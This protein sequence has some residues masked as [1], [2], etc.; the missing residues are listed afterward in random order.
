MAGGTDDQGRLRRTGRVRGTGSHGR[1]GRRRGAELSG[2][3]WGRL[4]AMFGFILALNAAGWG[5]YI[6]AVMPAPPR[7]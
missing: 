4:A 1:T 6:L 7:R 3:R 5:I 2:R